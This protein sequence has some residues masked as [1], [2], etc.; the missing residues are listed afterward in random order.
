MA[1]WRKLA[2]ASRGMAGWRNG[3]AASGVSG[4]VWRK[5]WQRIHISIMYHESL[6]WRRM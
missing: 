4:G 2:S 3:M 6:A 5:L 1:A